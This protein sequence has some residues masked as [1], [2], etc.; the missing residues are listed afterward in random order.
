MNTYDPSAAAKSA[1]APKVPRPATALLHDAPGARLV[2]FRIEP[3]QEV[4]P[5]T[6][7]STVILS[8]VSG[9]GV[10]LGAEGERDVRAGDLVVYEPHELHG[11]RAR[12]EQ[13]VIA[14]AITPR[15]GAAA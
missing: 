7:S 1:V 6:S 12:D 8:V 15:P 13:L 5:H 14:A 4:A 2:V 9:S 11:M 3:G 10:V